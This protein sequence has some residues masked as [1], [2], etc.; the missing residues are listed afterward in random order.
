MRTFNHIKDHHFPGGYPDWIL[1]NIEK[2][3]EGYVSHIAKR[4]D[5]D[6]IKTVL[7]IGSLNGIESVKFTE[8]LKDVRVYNFEPNPHSHQTVLLSTSGIDAI[9]CF[10]IAASDYN[11]K[12]KFYVTS[13]AGASSLLRP[14][15]TTSPAGRIL[16]EIEVDVVRLDDWA[17]ENNIPSVDVIWMDAQGSELNILQGMPELLKTVK[18]VYTECSTKP[19]YEGGV[20][21]N[22]VVEF[23]ESHG[24]DLVSEWIHSDI[25]GDWMFLRRV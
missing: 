13:N 3:V 10:N 5:L 7:D 15:N 18:A 12:S 6:S 4:F 8:K 16:N 19:Y 11:G 25:E 24:F 2:V 17:I 1:T 20:H 22:K 21:K 9:S 14:I 23:L